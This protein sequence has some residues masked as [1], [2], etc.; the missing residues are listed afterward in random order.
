MAN[1]F[2][3]RK[4]KIKIFKNDLKGLNSIDEEKNFKAKNIPDNIFRICNNCQSNILSEDVVLNHDVCPVCKFH[5]K[6]SVKSRIESTF[7]S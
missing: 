3:E 6:I 4:N 7:D 1:L 2:Q 5:F